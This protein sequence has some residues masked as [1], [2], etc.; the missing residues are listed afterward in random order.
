MSGT[1]PVCDNGDDVKEVSYTRAH[2][3][4]HNVYK[5]N[6]DIRLWGVKISAA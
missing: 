2:T 4:R 6:S 5:I 3:H 1:A